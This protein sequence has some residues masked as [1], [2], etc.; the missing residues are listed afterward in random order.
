MSW[1]IVRLRR[2]DT[3]KYTRHLGTLAWSTVDGRMGIRKAILTA[4]NRCQVEWER[5]I[6][7]KADAFLLFKTGYH[8]HDVREVYGIGI[9][10]KNDRGYTWT[11]E[12][13]G[14]SIV[15]EYIEGDL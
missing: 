5:N 10:V 12:H 3:G 9:R 2:V 1:G 15:K 8:A 4:T 11:F 13:G 7:P 6:P 14:Q